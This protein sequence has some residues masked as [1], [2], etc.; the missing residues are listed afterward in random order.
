MKY[1]KSICDGCDDDK[2]IVNKTHNLCQDCNRIRL[3]DQRGAKKKVHKIN[4]LSEKQRI[5]LK[6]YVKV[7]EAKR[8][9]QIEGGY[10][11]CYFCNEDLQDY[12]GRIDAHHTLGRDNDLLSEYKNIFF[13]HRTCH[14]IYHAYSADGLLKT[15]WYLDFMMRL[16]KLNK[17]GEVWQKELN[18]C[19]RAGIDDIELRID[20][21]I[22]E[23]SKKKYF[24]VRRK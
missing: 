7:R 16:R 23:L 12:E 5:K 17:I 13:T 14:T 20:K 21:R 19:K 10:Y 24:Y 6:E 11:K 18:R 4:Q 8:K 3:D 15:H 9:D 22:K 2:Y 1:I